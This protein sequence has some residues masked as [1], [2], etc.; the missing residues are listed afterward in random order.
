MPAST[1]ATVI[2]NVKRGLLVF[3]LALLASLTVFVDEVV[4]GEALDHELI[5][6]VVVGLML[7]ATAA[8]ATITV[9]RLTDQRRGLTRQH[10][11]TARQPGSSS[12]DRA[13][14]ERQTLDPLCS[15]IRTPNA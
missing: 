15:A 9:L 10:A 14:R 13:L 3:T 7:A 6:D 11:I 1:R 5:D 4:H 8:F 12:T 2:E